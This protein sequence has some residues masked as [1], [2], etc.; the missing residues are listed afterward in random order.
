MVRCLPA[1]FS[2]YVP[3]K[4]HLLPSLDRMGKQ[5]AWDE[6]RR[7]QNEKGRQVQLCHSLIWES[8]SLCLSELY[9]YLIDLFVC[10]FVKIIGVVLLLFLRKFGMR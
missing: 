9:E 8:I 4:I 6:N 3:L 5:A 1:S 7:Y 2:G 10:V